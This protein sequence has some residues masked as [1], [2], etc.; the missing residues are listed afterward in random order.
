MLAA[1]ISHQTFQFA[2]RRSFDIIEMRRAVQHVELAQRCIRV[3]PMGFSKLFT[4]EQTF[5][6]AT[7]ESKYHPAFVQFVRRRYKRKLG[8]SVAV[9]EARAKNEKPE[10]GDVSAASGSRARPE[11]AEDNFRARD[12][13]DDNGQNLAA[14]SSILA[15]RPAPLFLASPP[16]DAIRASVA[17]R[18]R[19]SGS[20]PRRAG[21]IWVASTRCGSRTD[22]RHRPGHSP[23]AAD[24]HRRGSRQQSGLPP[25]P[26]DHRQ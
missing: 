3:T 21:F 13:A 23:Q 8:H 22:R 15:P 26:E 19:R 1:A 7:L 17:P 4:H 16:P 9:Q 6:G 12:A 5:G 18:L 10:T 24:R 20:Q 11:I 14:R 2:C 25:W